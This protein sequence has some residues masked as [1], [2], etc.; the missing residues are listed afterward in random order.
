MAKKPIRITKETKIPSYPPAPSPEELE[1]HSKK[2][3]ILGVILF[4]V[5]MVGAVVY[6]FLPAPEIPIIEEITPPVEIGLHIFDFKFCEGL[7]EDFNCVNERNNIFKI[8]EPVRINHKI[9]GFYSEPSEEIPTAK[10]KKD[11]AF[12]DNEGN[13]IS[14]EHKDFLPTI[15]AQVPFTAGIPE[16]ISTGE[17]FYLDFSPGNYYVE[18]SITD[19]LAEE[20]I[21]DRFEFTIE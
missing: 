15:Y 7:D 14:Y 9:L 11:I 19:I 13:E 20:K 5:L 6:L 16:A 21:V 12:F 3:M 4:L 2:F 10:L 8:G 18:I 17:I 1:D